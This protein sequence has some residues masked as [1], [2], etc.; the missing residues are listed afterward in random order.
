MIEVLYGGKRRGVYELSTYPVQETCSRV[1][2]CVAVGAVGFNRNAEEGSEEWLNFG[3]G[4][5]NCDGKIEGWGCV[6]GED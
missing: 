6:G 1:D 4:C 3:S 5:E 2:Q